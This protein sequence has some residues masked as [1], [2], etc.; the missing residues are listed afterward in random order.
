MTYQG[1]VV[2]FMTVVLLQASLI[3][4][5]VLQR[6]KLRRSQSRLRELSARLITAQE[7]ERKRIARELHDDFGQRVAALRIEL[8]VLSREDRGPRQRGAS[9]AFRSVLS[10]T[11][12]L[13]TDLRDLSH[14]LHSSRLQH[15]GLHAALEDLCSALGKHHRISVAVRA[16]TMAAA[17]PTE[18]ALCLYRVA[19]EAVHNAVHHGGAPHIEVTLS[20]EGSVLRMQISDTGK[21]F[22][23]SESSEGFGLASMRERL[24]MIGGSLLVQSR[25][26]RG[27]A[28]TA[29]VDLQPRD[30]AMPRAES[31]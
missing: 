21:G 8:G 2:V 10:Q 3:L 17:V 20:A 22:D 30:S 25:P 13:A 27:T 19:Q 15:L 31:A 14:A 16:R 11:D 4:L 29:F 1:Y 9:A 23:A 28:V 24:N 5:L 6:R 18:V 12:A 26:G 7:E